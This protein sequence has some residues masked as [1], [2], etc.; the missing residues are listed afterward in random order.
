MI[1]A[2][3][4]RMYRNQVL[5][6]IDAAC[7]MLGPRKS[8]MVLRVGFLGPGWKKAIKD[9][10]LKGEPP[11]AAAGFLLAACFRNVIANTLTP[12]QRAM[13][14]HALETQ[15]G[16]DH[17]A[18]HFRAML[19][20]LKLMVNEVTYQAAVYEV[21]GSLRGLTGEELDNFRDG[22]LLEDVL[23]QHENSK[24]GP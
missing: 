3:R 19:G 14:L 16:S 23:R 2:I 6:N 11:F 15:N 21:V 10:Y 17:T 8:K 1:N 18:N 7:T 20:A 4:A 13:T 5:K 22:N 24:P 12:D 9:L